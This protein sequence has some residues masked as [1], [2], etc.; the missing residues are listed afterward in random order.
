[1][2][3]GGAHCGASRAAWGAP[4]MKGALALTDGQLRL[5]R[6]TA[7]R[8]PVERRDGFLRDVARHLGGPEVS[9]PALEAAIGAALGYA[10]PVFLCDSASVPTAKEETS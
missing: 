8:L 6:H 2:A 10:S 3:P 7:N 9:T 4:P 5:L 1:A